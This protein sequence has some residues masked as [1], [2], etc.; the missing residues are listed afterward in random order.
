MQ[1]IIIVICHSVRRKYIIIKIE[2]MP[3]TNTHIHTHEQAEIFSNSAHNKINII[4]D[5]YKYM[6]YVI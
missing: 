5:I 3:Y 6:I 2:Y 4:L 1:F